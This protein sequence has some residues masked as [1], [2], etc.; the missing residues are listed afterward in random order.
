MAILMQHT[1]DIRVTQK[2]AAREQRFVVAG[3]A[4]NNGPH[5]GV[6]GSPVVTVRGSSWSIVIQS[7]IGNTWVNST[8]QIQFPTS[9]ASGFSILSDDY[10]ANPDLD[11]N[12]LVLHC[13]P[14]A[15][16]GATD[17]FTYGNVSCYTGICWRNPCFRGFIVIDSLQALAEALRYPQ[18]KEYL[19]KVY[20]DRLFEV[21]V[22]LPVPQP[23]PPPFIPMMLPVQGDA[24]LP[25]KEATLFRREIV[26][27]VATKSAG[28]KAAAEETF[29][30][31]GT[32]RYRGLLADT[33]VF[34]DRSQ[35]ATLLDKFRF[36]CDVNPMPFSILRFLEYDR[37]NAELAGGAYTGTGNRQVLGSTITD[38]FGNYV[39]R[40]QR[41][42]FE[43]LSEADIDRAP[44]ENL[45][46][47]ARPDLIVQLLDPY[48]PGVVLRESALFANVTTFK[49]VNMCFQC[50]RGPRPC[51]GQ[52]IIQYI[53]DLLVIQGASG[54]RG[55]AGNILGNTG[56]ISNPNL[57]CAAW[58]GRLNLIACLANDAIKYYT[59]RYKLPSEAGWKLVT[60]ESRLPRFNG[61]DP[62]PVST[63]IRRSRSLQID[64]VMTANVECFENVENSADASSWVTTSN[65]KA[66]LTTSIYVNDK[67]FSAQQGTIRFR[68]E[69]YDA[70]GNKISTVDE[71][72]DLYLDNRGVEA[73]IDPNV[74][75]G[76]ETLGN[77]ALFTLPFTEVEGTKVV[78][79]ERVPITIR[80]RAKQDS[81]F[82][83][84]YAVTIAKGAVGN[85]GL[86]RTA[87]APAVSH[88]TALPT[89]SGQTAVG[90][91]YTDSVNLVSCSFTGTPDEPGTVGDYLELTI[92]PEN[93]WLE[94][95]QNF[96]AFRIKVH[97]HLR[98][99]D[100]ENS[101]PYYET[102]EVLI[103]I[104]R[105]E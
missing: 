55:G 60:E 84:Q 36:I 30:P 105:P 102:N 67:L 24:M 73:D 91:T 80:F 33:A 38:S 49:R 45:F 65:K 10:G 77:C 19:T 1:W 72:I 32:A 53:G 66:D 89:G 76:I 85:I 46:V 56:K 22:K 35:L 48:D 18:L 86:A 78:S 31:V 57:L 44:G 25:Q 81:G 90:R 8:E 68:I 71:T 99:T 21:P 7:K 74:R 79:D 101:N 6:V 61:I 63:S 94:A 2:S 98:H 16:S 69:G 23:D 70:A 27:K 3:A 92:R 88:T 15:T 62:L 34:T 12:D 29:I 93:N 14:V 37:T 26:E 64:G 75:L 95:D 96:C 40:Y 58:R 51:N 28:A 104:E 41:S 100:G 43:D 11:F 39:F 87:P 9:A 54:T 82:M 4:T 5:P 59:V 42:D 97:G 103:G 13:T 50:A 83:G 47:Q 20:P 52:G 17:Y